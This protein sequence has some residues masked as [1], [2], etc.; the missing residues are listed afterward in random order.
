MRG[1]PC[2][3][4]SGLLVACAAEVPEGPIA[5]PPGGKADVWGSDDRT[6]TGAGS[7]A[8]RELA[9]TGAMLLAAGYLETRTDGAGRI[10]GYRL[11]E[12][13]QTLQ[14]RYGLCP[15]VRFADQP[16]VGFC[17]ATLVA[18]D[19][20]LTSGHCLSRTGGSAE[21]ARCEDV[22]VIFD[23]VVDGGDVRSFGVDD[24]YACARVEALRNEDSPEN[25]DWALV[26]LD[27]P[28]EGRAPA[29]LLRGTPRAGE[30]VI[31]I[32][33]PS[34][35]PQKLAPGTVTDA[36]DF[37]TYGRHEDVSFSYDADLFGGASGGSVFVT[38]RGALAGVP[39]AFSGRDYVSRPDGLCNVVGVCGDNTTCT[40]PPLAC[41]T[42]T[43]LRH[44]ERDA[45]HLLEELR[46]VGEA[47]PPPPPCAHS[48][49]DYRYAEG[50]CAHDWRCVDGCLEP[51]SCADVC[52][53]ECRDYLFVEGQCY[54]A[55]RCTDGCLE[56]AECD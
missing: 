54:G 1:L 44:L 24:V 21:T 47:D 30:A 34:G 3:L 42:S 16:A 46:L 31:Q 45:P 33:H 28:V 4:V 17:S 50:E 12:H 19:L 18:P 7:A 13:T 29:A 9:R 22:R 41:A 6:E 8:V 5:P 37:L 53:R 15:D 32:A 48:C 26:R 39:A 55:W 2:V 35:L 40:T 27:R 43:I 11:N 56:P 23:F 52:E 51:T 38:A 49:A 10:T 14:A 20:V 36:S 25:L